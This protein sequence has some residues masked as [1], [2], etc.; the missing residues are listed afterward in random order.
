MKSVLNNKGF[1]LLELMVV[2]AII[3]IVAAIGIPNYL[4]MLPHLRLKG[5][6]MDISNVLQAARMKAVTNNKTY[7]VKFDYSNDSYEMGEWVS[8]TTIINEQTSVPL[9]WEG[10]DLVD[11][12]SSANPLTKLYDYGDPDMGAVKFNS[13][14]TASVDTTAALNQKGAVYLR[15]NPIDNNEELRVVITEVTGKIKIQHLAGTSWE[16]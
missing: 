8:G 3:G 6:V 12:G 15:N 5:A 16:D 7:M 13:D 2:V 11:L 10:I 14:G 1:T 9:E 4:K